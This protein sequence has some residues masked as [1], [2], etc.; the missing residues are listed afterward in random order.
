MLQRYV[1]FYTIPQFWAEKPIVNE[2]LKDMRNLNAL[3]SEQV[4]HYTSQDYDLIIC[5][6]GMI[7]FSVPALERDFTPTRSKA[8]MADRMV[9]MVSF[10]EQYL[11]YVNSLYL[12][13]DSC[14]QRVSN[15]HSIELV[16]ITFHEAFR[17]TVHRG[18][19]I[20]V[21]QLQWRYG[22]GMD[23]TSDRDPRTLASAEARRLYHLRTEGRQ[24]VSKEVFDLL[25]QG[26][27]AV[28]ASQKLRTRLSIIASS[29]GE[30]KNAH[31]GLSLVLAWFVVESV[32]KEKWEIWVMS[33]NSK[34][35][36]GT[37][38]VNADR[39]KLLLKGQ[40]YHISVVSNILELSDVLFFKLHRQIDNVRRYR[41]D[42]VHL[43]PKYRCTSEQ[44][45][46][47][48]ELAISLATEGELLDIAPNLY[49]PEY[50][51]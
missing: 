30:Y 41:N 37:K 6:D 33:K 22:I 16:P 17:I 21:V 19:P 39:R 31:Y 27:S 5:R 42:I 12:V 14:I 25:N 20:S 28:A 13:L 9:N 46:E 2:H 45:K 15:R 32:L 7:M 10:W 48:I 11:D 38:R 35:S 44:C 43:D 1:G 51:P 26:F 50:G 4:F 3:M 29:I 47:A 36:D 34:F 18:Q 23:P 24:V 49:L 40:D 8:S